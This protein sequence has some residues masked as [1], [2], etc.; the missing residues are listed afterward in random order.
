MTNNGVRKRRNGGLASPNRVAGKNHSSTVLLKTVRNVAIVGTVGLFFVVISLSYNNTLPWRMSHATNVLDRLAV[1]LGLQ[2]QV[3]AVVIDAGSTGTRVLAF[4]FHH[5]LLDGSLKLDAELFKEVKPGLSSYAK[6]PEASATSL[7]ELLSAAL[8]F[9]P[10]EAVSRTPL[11][12]RATAGLRLLPDHRAD[13][14]LETARAEAE[15][16]GFLTRPDAVRI[17]SGTDEGL[18]SWFTVNFLLDRLGGEPGRSVA[19]FDLGGGS[20]QVT[21]APTEAATMHAAPPGSIVEVSA[22]KAQAGVYS[23][24]RRSNDRVVYARSYLGIGLMAAR[25]TILTAGLDGQNSSVISECVNP[26]VTTKWSYGGKTYNISGVSTSK[27]YKFIKGKGGLID[28]TE[29][30]VDFVK[31]YGLAERFLSGRLHAPDELRSRE[32]YAISYYFDR[33]TEAGLVDPFDG[34]AVTVEQLMRAARQACETPNVEQPLACLDLTYIAALLH[35]GLQLPGE[36]LLR[37]HKKIDEHET[38]WALGAA[39]HTLTNHA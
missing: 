2:E 29:P 25:H 31:C 16:S 33:A 4:A 7:R 32:V 28:K 24:S 34:G 21:F 3:Y 17:M 23:Q 18:F 9:V 1:R 8:Q 15:R 38:S 11:V 12:L 30:I 6:E 27:N 5:S 26:V 35:A 36:H 39:F 14:L 19:V 10:A 37:L 13:A 20:T 22:M